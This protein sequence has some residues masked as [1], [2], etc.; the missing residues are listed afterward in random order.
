MIDNSMMSDSDYFKMQELMLE[1]LQEE[2]EDEWDKEAKE[3]A[4]QLEEE[5]AHQAWEDRISY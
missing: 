3:Y 4:A 1:R 2:L 5:A